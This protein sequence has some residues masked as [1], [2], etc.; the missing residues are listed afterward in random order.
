MKDDVSRKVKEKG[1]RK[2]QIRMKERG[3][4]EMESHGCGLSES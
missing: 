2:A 1:V 4:S 3:A